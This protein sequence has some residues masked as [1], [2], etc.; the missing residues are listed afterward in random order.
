MVLDCDAVVEDV[1][2]YPQATGTESKVIISSLCV[3][4]PGWGCLVILQADVAARRVTFR[5]AQKNLHK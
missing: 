4:W 1:L 5:S 3:F 2:C